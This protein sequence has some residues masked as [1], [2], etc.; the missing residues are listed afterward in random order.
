MYFSASLWEKSYFR[1]HKKWYN[2]QCCHYQIQQLY[3]LSHSFIGE[4]I[5]KPIQPQWPEY[6]EPLDELQHHKQL[7]PYFVL[8]KELVGNP[9]NNIHHEGHAAHVLPEHEET[10]SDLL[11]FIVHVA[12]PCVEN[13]VE[14]ETEIDASLEDNNGLEVDLFVEADLDREDY[15]KND[16]YEEDE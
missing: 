4:D 2:H 11:I 13:D 1:K 8:K 6:L 14:D 9:S 10:V 7:Q 12:A 15:G 16:H 3:K 5:G